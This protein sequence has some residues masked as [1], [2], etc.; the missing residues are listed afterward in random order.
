[1]QLVRFNLLLQLLSVRRYF[2]L[3]LAV[4]LHLMSEI[5]PKRITR[6]RVFSKNLLTYWMCP[7]E[8][9]IFFNNI[10]S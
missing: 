2:N 1:M 3:F 8:F 6:L 10:F 9:N 7:S 4:I 5:V